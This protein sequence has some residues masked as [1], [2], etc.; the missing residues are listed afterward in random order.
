ML[1]LSFIPAALIGAGLAFGLGFSTAFAGD[2][3]KF[4]YELRVPK[5]AKFEP[6]TRFDLVTDSGSSGTR[7]HLTKRREE[8]EWVIFADSEL[9]F[10]DEKRRAMI[11][12]TDGQA[13]QVFRLTLPSRL[14]PVD[15]TKWQR[16]DY[17]EKTD[18]G[19]TFMHDSKKHDRSTNSP[20]GSF[21]LRFKITESK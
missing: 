8:G 2:G 5:N 14:K 16:P 7:L 6:L 21:E 12:S 18:A 15:W 17:T 3:Y 19:W 9:V 1:A 10:E 4:S 11:V 13:S 20:P